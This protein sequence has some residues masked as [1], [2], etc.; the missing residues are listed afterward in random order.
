MSERFGP[1]I[2]P[3]HKYSVAEA[4]ARLK[5]GFYKKGVKGWSYHIIQKLI[6]SGKL[7]AGDRNRSG[8]VIYITER[9][10]QNY[11]KASRLAAQV[12]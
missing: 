4:G 12:T 3:M 5:Y 7:E 9:A 8:K 6:D 2:H 10:I 1:P 11:E